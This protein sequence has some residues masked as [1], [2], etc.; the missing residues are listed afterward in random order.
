MPVDFGFLDSLVMPHPIREADCYVL[1]E[2]LGGASTLWSH[3]LMQGR[4]RELLERQSVETVDEEVINSD[5]DIVSAVLKV[6]APLSVSERQNLL[7]EL[8][9]NSPSG[10]SVRLISAAS[11]QEDAIEP[12]ELLVEH[13]RREFAADSQFIH[14]G[15]SCTK[16][17][18]VNTGLFA[19]STIH[20]SL[21]RNDEEAMLL[22]MARLKDRRN[23]A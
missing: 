15:N 16:L 11:S 12:K 1:V 6:T 3:S 10:V 9:T 14:H 21:L 22:L 7:T 20:R 18:H 19:R 5:G 17:T 13:F 8:T 2:A 4:L 23:A